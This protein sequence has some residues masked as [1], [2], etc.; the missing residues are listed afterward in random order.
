[1]SR[2]TA[3]TERETPSPADALETHPEAFPEICPD[4]GA[5][6]PEPAV[7]PPVPHRFE[8]AST[9]P[10]IAPSAAHLAARLPDHWA[11]QMATHWAPDWS[12]SEPEDA[13]ELRPDWDCQSCGAC[14]SYSAEWPRFTLETDEAL[15]LIPPQFVAADERGMRCEDNRCSALAGKV[16]EHTACQAYAVRPEVCRDCLPGDHACRTARA[17]YGIR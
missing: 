1:M 12:G 16:G 8:A 6:C 3:A 11:A 5:A 4:G 9:T 15:A 17:A 13:A 10:L 14:C 2:T 7:V